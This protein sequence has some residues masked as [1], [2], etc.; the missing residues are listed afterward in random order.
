MKILSFNFFCSV[1]FIFSGTIWADDFKSD[2]DYYKIWDGAVYGDVVI[3][4]FRR[5]F[6][7]VKLT[8]D[9]NDLL[10]FN[11]EGV[12]AKAIP[13]LSTDLREA[14]Q[15]L[16]NNQ[17]QINSQPSV[18]DKIMSVGFTVLPDAVSE[19]L[20]QLKNGQ[21]IYLSRNS[22]KWNRSEL[23]DSLRAW[24]LSHPDTS[25]APHEVMV[26][27]LEL[28]RGKV[29]V[30]WVIAWNV[31]RDRWE[32]A[33]VRNY[34]AITQKMISLS[35]ERAFW[36]GGVHFV[37]LD[38][39]KEIYGES[40]IVTAN[41]HAI[42]NREQRFYEMLVTKRGDDFSYFYHRVGVELFS[43]V[44][45]EYS[46]SKWLGNMAGAAGAIGEWLK[47]TTTAG[48]NKERLKR[49]ANDVLASRSGSRIYQL[50]KDRKSTKVNSVENL[51]ANIYLNRAKWLYGSDYKLKKNQGAVY[52]GTTLSEKY[53]DQTFESDEL[54]AIFRH[55]TR[56]DSNILSP[57]F[58]LS[59][60]SGTILHQGL[61]KY[62][63]SNTNDHELNSYIKDYV[64]GVRAYPKINDIKV[65]L[66]LN[67]DLNEEFMKE[68]APDY[69]LERS[70]ETLQ[71]LLVRVLLVK[72][73][74]VDKNQ[75]TLTSMMRES[76]SKA[77]NKCASFY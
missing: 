43:M 41:G 49:V 70:K 54:K 44:M 32:A 72:K 56:Y 28:A 23:E 2:R 33:A 16:K 74:T 34:G 14:P 50:V 45:A 10:S 62:L 36:A 9:L 8:I 76:A 31:L 12:D 3:E 6:P 21:V 64:D 39:K 51:D 69:D 67:R 24:I 55:A 68:L 5:K 73:K 63:N 13:N 38:P 65:D 1:F 47:Y 40:K 60:D 46:R 57:T 22:E 61:V 18:V 48:V 59:N 66:D 29:L 42:E 58:L 11:K 52:K 4:D 17:D 27:S 75:L 19:I 53:W 77:K 37:P 26:K 71:R 25:L 15:K 35:G 20:D 7:D 30:A